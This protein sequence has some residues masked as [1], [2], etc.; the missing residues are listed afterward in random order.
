MNSNDQVVTSYA[1]APT[2]TVAAGGITFAYRE[3]GPSGGVPVVF[4]VHLA[5]TLDNWDPRVI[6]AVAAG[7]HVIAVDNRGV[8]A[9][10]GSVP[11]TVEAMADDAYA[12]IAA[13]GYVTVDVVGFSLGGFVAQILVERHPDLVRRLVLAGTGPRGGRG[14]VNV[15]VVTFSGIT[16]AAIAR[17]D[18]KEFLFFNRNPEGKRAGAAFIQRLEERTAD[19]DAPMTVSGFLTQLVAIVR[20]GIGTP[21]DLSKITQ[22]TLI[23]NGDNDRTV[24]S[25]LSYEMHRRIPG[26]ELVIYRDAGHGGVFQHHEAF[27]PALVEF[28][29]RAETS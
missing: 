9:S 26:S 7:H 4:L 11:D 12:F 27:A 2:R 10:T 20:W 5:A 21:S 16:R 18:P 14:I 1:K 13:L 17:R 22:P 28:L 3:L 29:D 25:A 23:A 6:D 15:P 19:L 24:P 8:G